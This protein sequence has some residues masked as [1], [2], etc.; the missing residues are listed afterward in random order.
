ME[1]AKCFDE[2]HIS[3]QRFATPD[4]A[5][6]IMNFPASG[7]PGH[8]SAARKVSLHQLA[9]ISEV[10]TKNEYSLRYKMVGKNSYDVSVRL[11]YEGL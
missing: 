10:V 5:A 2:K 8:R 7:I 4:I 9:M 11:L 3:Q 1:I 6:T